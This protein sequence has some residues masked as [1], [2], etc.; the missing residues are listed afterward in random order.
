MDGWMDEEQALDQK[1]D[2]LAAS[3]HLEIHISRKEN[4]SLSFDKA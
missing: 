3:R 1:E 4:R 2:C